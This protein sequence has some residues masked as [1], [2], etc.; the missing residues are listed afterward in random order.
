MPVTVYTWK[1]NGSTT[2]PAPPG[3]GNVYVGNDNT[4]EINGDFSAG[5]PKDFRLKIDLSP[6]TYTPSPPDD[7]TSDSN[8]LRGTFVYAQAL[9]QGR[10][11]LL[12]VTTRVTVTDL[13]DN[14]TSAYTQECSIIAG[15]RPKLAV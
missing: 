1:F 8:Y 11:N 3:G 12:G 5:A 14:T 13:L 4:Y 2:G 6:G 9:D 15:L 10:I 7:T